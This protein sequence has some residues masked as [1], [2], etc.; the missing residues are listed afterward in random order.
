MEY[1]LLNVGFNLFGISLVVQEYWDNYWV[2]DYLL[3]CKD[4]DLECIGV[5]GFFGGGI[6]IVY[7][8]GLD[9]CVKVVVICSFFF[10]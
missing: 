10:I 8:I 2:L 7:Y 4:I 1:I 5:Y 9:F 6:Q 3:I